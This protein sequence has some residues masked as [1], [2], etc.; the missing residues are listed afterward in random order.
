[1]PDETR[2]R[3]QYR[4]GHDHLIDVTDGEILQGEH[5]PTVYSG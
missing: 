2:Y 1:M 5:F 3:A 4:H